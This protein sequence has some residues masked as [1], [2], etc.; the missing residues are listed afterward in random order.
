MW[1]VYNDME[2]EFMKFLDYVPPAQ[3][4]K[5]VYSYN[6]LR[7]MLQIG[8][9]IDTAFKEMALYSKF[10]GNVKCEEIREKVIKGKTVTISLFRE[11]FEPIYDLSSMAVVAKSPKHFTLLVDRFSP[12]SEFGKSKKPKWWEAYNE[13]K[14]NWL[15][16]LKK[17]NVENTLNALGGAFLL[18]VIHEPSLIELAKRGVARVF[19]G[20]QQIRVK[21]ELL[22]KVIKREHP[23]GAAMILVDSQLFRW[24]FV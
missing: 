22:T 17:A 15:K 18:N 11:A 4:H 14:H 19:A 21:E 1:S 6:L 5:K 16:N 2:G 9:Y 23:L 3:E 8:G 7:L 13:V 20:G 10:D 24:R 12:F